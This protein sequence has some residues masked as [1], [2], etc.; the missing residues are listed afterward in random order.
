MNDLV[1][2]V[3]PPG[4]SQ[5][6]ELIPFGSGVFCHKECLQDLLILG[7]EADKNVL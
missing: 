7:Y 3:P 5:T 6:F 4:S 2:S 1:L